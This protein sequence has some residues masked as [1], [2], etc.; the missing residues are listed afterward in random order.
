MWL[1]L[2]C[3]KIVIIFYFIILFYFFDF[4]VLN[5]CF[6]LK[7]FNSFL[8]YDKTGARLFDFLV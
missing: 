6:I 2:A 1:I 5:W 4:A 8:L 7:I 3:K